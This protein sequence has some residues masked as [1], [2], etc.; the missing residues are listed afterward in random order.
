MGGGGFQRGRGKSIGVVMKGRHITLKY[1]SILKKIIMHARVS[2]LVN[3]FKNNTSYSISTN[4]HFQNT[5]DRRA[6]M[7]MY[8]NM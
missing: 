2:L 7:L 5:M 4:T 6:N 3:K 1:F 8:G